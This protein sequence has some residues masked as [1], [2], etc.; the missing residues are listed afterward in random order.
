MNPFGEEGTD[1]DDLRGAVMANMERRGADK[2]IRARIRAEVYASLNNEAISPPEAIPNEVYLAGEIIKDFLVRM[3]CEN[4]LSVLS[5]ELGL[6]AENSLERDFLLE[7]VGV[8]SSKERDIPA[9]LLLIQSQKE[10][11]NATSQASEN[12]NLA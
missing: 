7:E 1:S 11:R 9:L 2:A 6:D 4:T 3:K 10:K 12:Q 8:G 5:Q